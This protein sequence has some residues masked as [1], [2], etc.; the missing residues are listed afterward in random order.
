[1]TEPSTNLRNQIRTL[2]KNNGLKQIWIAQQ[3]GISQKHLSQMLTGRV[4]LSLN[5]AQRIAALSGHTVT[6][7]V[8]SASSVD[9][10]TCRKSVHLASHKPLPVP[11]CPWC[12]AAAVA[13]CI[14]TEEAWPPHCPCRTERGAP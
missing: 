1:V 6:V 14:C 7:T 12:T 9:R 2:I 8:G 10:C 5:W 11:G 4:D 13:P 3:L